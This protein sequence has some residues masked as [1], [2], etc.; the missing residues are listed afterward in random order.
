MRHTI[1]RKIFLN[2]FLIVAFAIPMYSE[3]KNIFRDPGFGLCQH[4]KKLEDLCYVGDRETNFCAITSL[5]QIVMHQR[6]V[7]LGK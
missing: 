3:A 4:S 7:R 1:V 5:A 6:E 2:T